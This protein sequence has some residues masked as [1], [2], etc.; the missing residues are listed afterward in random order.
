MSQDTYI[1]RVELK[2]RVGS[3]R[4]TDLG[5]GRKFVYFSVMTQEVAEVK[6]QKTV[7]CTWH[8]VVSFEDVDVQKGALVHLFGKIQQIP[9]AREDG[10]DG[11]ACQIIAT[12]VESE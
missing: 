10:S 5:D 4:K 12:E 9:Y 11:Y 1:N 8:N 3:V 6:E 2:G 7:I